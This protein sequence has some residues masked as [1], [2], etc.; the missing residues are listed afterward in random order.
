VTESEAPWHTQSFH[1]IKSKSSD[2]TRP[3]SEF[4]GGDDGAIT[5]QKHVKIEEFQITGSLVPS[6]T[7]LFLTERH[8]SQC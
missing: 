4:D 3:H 6:I 1:W 8:K 7:F 2:L 5:H